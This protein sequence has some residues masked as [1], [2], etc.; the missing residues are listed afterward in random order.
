M[1]TQKQKRIEKTVSILEADLTE[2]VGQLREN[3]IN[4][5]GFS[6]AVLQIHESVSLLDELVHGAKKD[7]SKLR[8]MTLETATELYEIK[9]AKLQR[10]CVAGEIPSKKVGQIR[11]VTPETMDALFRGDAK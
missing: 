2:V 6:Q 8:A 7:V 3:G 4:H 1:S 5:K 10:M 11:Y 9:Y